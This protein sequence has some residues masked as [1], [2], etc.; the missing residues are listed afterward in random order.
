MIRVTCS[1][2]GLQIMVPP[3]V[4]G[5]DGVCFG[6]G[7]TLQV[8]VST[9]PVS[10]TQSIYSVGDHI[11]NRYVLE[12]KIGLGG[13]GVVYKAHDQLTDEHV[14]LKF[15]HPRALRTQKGQQNF[16]REAQI[17]RR[18]RHENI[19]AVHD[20]STTPEGVLYLSMELLEGR[21]LRQ[22]LRAHRQAKKFVGVRVAVDYTAQILSALDYAHG[23]V[24]H[25]DLKPENAMILPGE[26]LKVLDFG[27]AVAIQDEPE[28]EPEPGEEK[29]NVIGT[30]AYASPEQRD[31]QA[32]DFRSDIYT[33]GLVLRELLTLRTPIDEP[34][35]VLE[36]RDDVA[37]QLVEV[38]QKALEPR[39]DARWQSA[40]EFRD[41][42]LEVYRDSYKE[43]RIGDLDPD[44]ESGV[45]AENMAYLEGGS[46][47]MGSAEVREESPEFE[48]Y[49]EPFYM[50][51]HPVT[52]E[53]YAEFIKATDASHPKFWNDSEFNGDR[54]P[55]TGVSLADA[56]A[57]AEWAGKR[58]PTEKEWEFAARGKVN[59]KYPWGSFEP[60][61]TRCNF[62]DYLGMPSI[63]TMH[64]TG[65]TPEEVL[66][67]AGN[68]YEWTL[69]AFIPYRPQDSGDSTKSAE[70]R[71]VVRG[72]SWHSGEL[73]LR[74]THR[75]GLFHEAQ[76]ATVGF[77][78]ILPGSKV[79]K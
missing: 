28:L 53:Q 1:H 44:V 19:V 13:M 8:P 41:T 78:C 17:V 58:L 51:L 15:M 42:L 64:D 6:C 49:V 76:L 9:S 59:R 39:K 31:H 12:T 68:V 73:E 43:I 33:V 57:Y 29:P 47:L 74:T 50:D 32:V 5:R 26:R 4:Q 7:A 24:V 66:D 61:T 25:R 60:D 2:C 56:M 37:P 23:M 71:R 18:L 48:A 62:G 75:K 14:A 35:S 77:R 52:C 70:P 27:L 3:T 46:F 11:A 54:Q 79:K 72:G 21:S 10:Q 36:A 45:S 22:L 69:D 20:V 63:V 55:V 38:I 30:H 34:I 67:M 16:I 65:A 40:R